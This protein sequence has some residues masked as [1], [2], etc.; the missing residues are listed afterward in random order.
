MPDFAVRGSMKLPGDVVKIYVQG[1]FFA[2]SK[3]TLA[4][5]HG[6]LLADLVDKLPKDRDQDDEPLFIDREPKIFRIILNWLTYLSS[7]QHEQFSEVL[8]LLSPVETCLLKLDAQYFKLAK[9]CD[10]L[11]VPLHPEIHEE[12]AEVEQVK[13]KPITQQQLD[14]VLGDEK[15]KKVFRR[16]DVSGLFFVGAQITGSFFEAVGI[17][18]DL[19]GCLLSEVDFRGSDFTGA[20]F[21]EATIYRGLFQAATLDKLEATRVRDTDFR[22]SFIDF[23]AIDVSFS[24]FSNCSFPPGVKNLTNASFTLCHFSHITIADLLHS[25]FTGST[26]RDCGG[27]GTHEEHLGGKLTDARTATSFALGSENAAV[28]QTQV[29]VAGHLCLFDFKMNAELKD[30]PVTTPENPSH[31]Y[32]GAFSTLSEH[33][34]PVRL[35]SLVDHTEINYSVPV[36]LGVFKLCQNAKPY[37]PVC[38][39]CAGCANTVEELSAE[40]YAINFPSIQFPIIITVGSD[41]EEQPQQ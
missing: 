30:D 33:D 17:G 15:R 4:G 31:G 16:R 3:A 41:H 29:M 40:I 22:S 23:S 13:L 6:S 32:R 34:V 18:A 35:L 24:Q 2:T 10:V 27:F 26:F 5:E 19:S 14:L 37:T 11:G 36:R 25:D 12:K 38:N 1:A 20:D 21:S 9:L 8:E 7:G 28:T 39:E